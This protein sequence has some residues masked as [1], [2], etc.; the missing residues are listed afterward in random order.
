MQAVQMVGCPNPSRK[1][2][3][4]RKRLSQMVTVT[5]LN[6]YQPYLT[7]KIIPFVGILGHAQMAFPLF[8]KHWLYM[9]IRAFHPWGWSS[10]FLKD[11]KYIK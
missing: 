2:R 11:I 5:I 10:Q 7:I 9:C 6:H 8:R 3:F 4:R 1:E